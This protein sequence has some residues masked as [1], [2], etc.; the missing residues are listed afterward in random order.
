MHQPPCNSL[1]VSFHCP[2]PFLHACWMGWNVDVYRRITSAR[3]KCRQMK[4]GRHPPA[5][6]MAQSNACAVATCPSAQTTLRGQLVFRRRVS[7]KL[8]FY[9]LELQEAEGGS[10]GIE[11]CIK[12]GDEMSEMQVKVFRDRLRLGDVVVVDGAMEECGRTLRVK[13]VAVVQGW[14]ETHP[15]EHFVPRRILQPNVKEDKIDQQVETKG[16]GL[17]KFFLNTGRCSSGETCKFLHVNGAI[18]K[19]A[20]LQQRMERKTALSDNPHKS[21]AK[22]K[23][24]RAKVFVDWLVDTYGSSRLSMGTGVL[25]VAGGRGNLAFELFTVRGI[26]C[27][28]IDPRE[29]KFTRRQRSTLSSVS[30]AA[31]R[32][33]P[34]YLQR[35]FNSTL[36]LDDKYKALLQNCSICIGMHPDEATENIVDFSLLY[37]KPFAVV[38]CCVF[39]ALFPE[40]SL[41]GKHVVTHDDFVEF[42]ALKSGASI[43]HLKFCGLSKV[44]YMLCTEKEEVSGTDEV[45]QEGI[46]SKTV[47]CQCG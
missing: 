46:N 8:V 42:L 19:Q 36:W 40:R 43:D 35:L 29:Q 33:A 4:S 23:R 32:G 31:T 17:C 38:P 26:P 47:K 9:E 28:T 16:A 21:E 20:F 45:P 6:A 22:S 2:H 27:T 15:H 11:L 13:D 14:K 44:V 34:P 10:H 12:A 37:K 39:P 3:S 7:R 5:H 1:H 18:E 41:H 30:A 25:D 24:K